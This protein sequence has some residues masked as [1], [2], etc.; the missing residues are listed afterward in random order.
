MDPDADTAPCTRPALSGL[1]MESGSSTEKKCAPHKIFSP[2]A[3]CR[4]HRTGVLLAAPLR[5]APHIRIPCVRE[6]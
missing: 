4:L 3:N 2:K 6:R 5:G 1:G